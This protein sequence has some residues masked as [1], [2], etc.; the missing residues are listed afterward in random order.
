MI[1]AA[2]TTTKTKTVEP[3]TM[4]TLK[5]LFLDELADM[6]DAERRIVRALPKI[7]N[8][9][10]CPD[11]KAAIQAHLIE[12]KGHVTRIEQIFKSFEEKARGKVCHATVGILQEG[13][14]IASENK[15][16]PTINAALISAAQKVEHYEMASYDCLHVWAGLLGNKQAAGLL[17]KTLDEEKAA[18]ATLT[19]LALATSN[20]EALCACDENESADE[21][22]VKK[23]ANLRRGIRP[24]RLGRKR[25]TA[26]V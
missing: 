19:K 14:E 12:T 9:A 18:N 6:Y 21:I 8:A 15:G 16:E 23:P 20:Q 17:A 26:L 25:T 10:T 7:A 24:V 4:K 1:L 22:A 11:L 3:N 13:D 5:E 2:D